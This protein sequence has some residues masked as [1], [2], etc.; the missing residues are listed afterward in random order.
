MSP[1]VF[2]GPAPPSDVIGRDE[3]IAALWSRAVGGRFVLLLAPRRFGKTSVVHRLRRDAEDT[4]ELAVVLV[5]L[6]GVQTIADV[7]ARFRPAWSDLADGPLQKAADKVLRYLPEL[8]AGVG[9]VSVMARAPR[10]QD[11]AT[12]SLE[13]WLRVPDRVAERLGRRVLVVLDE[14]QAV[15]AVPPVD[16]VIRSVIQH[17]RERVSYL[18]AGSEQSLLDSLFS[19]R[20]APLYGQAERITLPGLDADPLGRFIDAKFAATGRAVDG[21]ALAALLDLAAGHPQRAM[22]LAHHLWEHTAEGTSADP[23][24]LADA[25]D[26]ALAYGEPEF[27]ATMA[28]LS[29]AQRKTLRLA[30]WGQP[31]Y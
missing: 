11:A 26:T 24:T 2:E 20:A 12:R 28:L 13:E 6:L 18:F 16:A 3:I 25:V 5:D 9:P 29:D 22:L 19:R 30:A 17:Q 4:K 21:P 23:A 1:F 8:T 27:T 10:D 31:L 14:F 15:A 7:V